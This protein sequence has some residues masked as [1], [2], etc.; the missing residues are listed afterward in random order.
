MNSIIKYFIIIF[1][2]YYYLF[3]QDNTN[4][5]FG[6]VKDIYGKPIVN[7]NVF[8]NNSTIG[9]TTDAEGKYT[10]KYI[11]SGNYELVVEHVSYKSQKEKIILL[12]NSKIELNFYLEEKTYLIEEIDIQAPMP[13]LWNKQLRIFKNYFLGRNEFTNDCKLVN[14]YD[15]NF[16]YT[17][18]GKLLAYANRLLIV[19]NYAL[20]YRLEILLLNFECDEKNETANFTFNTK[21]S[22]LT[23]SSLKQKEDWSYNRE[24]TYLGSP[25][26][27]I[28]SLINSN[29]SE[30]GFE[31][32]VEHYIDDKINS[33]PIMPDKIFFY[34]DLL[35]EYKIKIEGYLRIEFEPKKTR[36]WLYFEKKDIAVNYQRNYLNPFPSEVVFEGEW[37]K[38]G[39][40]TLLPVDYYEKNNY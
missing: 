38:I 33:I 28:N 29:T 5:I 18:E 26:H 9:T 22:E 20:G 31:L 21:F 14:E 34:D 30:E 10:I 37:S 12:K 1:S 2:L 19:E 16:E 24:L 40:S 13:I 32:Y 17:Q 25:V 27:F 11:H 3:A 36:S 39:I 6:I 4:Y 15:V 23:P 35:E 8:I 7:V